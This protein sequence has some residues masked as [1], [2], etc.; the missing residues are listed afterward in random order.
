[1]LNEEKRKILRTSIPRWLSHQKCVEPILLNWQV[2]LEYFKFSST[3]DKLKSAEF[4]YNEL[5]NDCN[6][7]C[8]LYLKYVLNYFNSVN[9]LFQ[10][11]KR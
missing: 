10:A 3:R 6:K 5:T 11:K 9:A 2:L 1:M 8:L 4:I 7:A